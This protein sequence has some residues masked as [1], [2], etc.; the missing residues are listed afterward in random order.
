MFTTL[1]FNNRVYTAETPFEFEEH[2]TNHSIRAEAGT[3]LLEGGVEAVVAMNKLGQA[4]L[5]S[6][7]RYIDHE[8][9]NRKATKVLTQSYCD[10]DARNV[11]STST[12]SVIELD[13]VYII[14][15]SY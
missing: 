11:P 5:E 10:Y 2:Y 14:K 1:G 13:G 3:T 4:S 7:N 15:P 8:K 9:A 6:M 12:A